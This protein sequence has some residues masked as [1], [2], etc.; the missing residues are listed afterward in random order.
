M[1]ASV[2]TRTPDT[3]TTLTAVCFCSAETDFRPISTG[4]ERDQESGNDYFG[5]RYYASTMGRFLSPDWSAK[6][7]PVPYASLDNPQTLNLYQYMR[8]NPL[9]GVDPD[10]H[11]CFWQD[12]AQGWADIGRRVWDSLEAGGES[13]FTQQG[14]NRMALNMM[15]GAVV[16]APALEDT[17]IAEAPATTINVTAAMSESLETEAPALTEQI[18]EPATGQDVYRVWGGESGPYGHSWTPT[19][20]ASVPAPRNSLG[21]PDANTG[22]QLT[23]GTL[24]DTTGV[25]TRPAKPLD[26]NAGGGPEYLVPDP[27]NQVQIKSIKDN[28]DN[29]M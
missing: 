14:A 3:S 1:Q 26:G 8:N 9:G 27:K 15:A 2:S 20:P 25:T 23:K 29:P 17:F 6:E 4:K 11:C 28:T 21:L 22:T 16:P 13:L 10:G 5:A 18:P 7:E 24:T 12:L 19:D